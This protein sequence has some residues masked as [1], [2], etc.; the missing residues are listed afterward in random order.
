MTYL[1]VVINVDTRSGFAENESNATEM[2]NGCKSIDFLIDGVQNKINFFEGLDK[3][4]I[5]F[6]D[7]HEAIPEGVLNTLRGMVDTLVIRK[8]DKRFGDMK[9]YNKF[10]DLNYLSALQMARGEYIAHFDQDCAA[11]TRTPD[12]VNN[13]IKHLD[14]YS[15]VSYPSHWSPRAVNDPNYDY[16][17][18]STR[19]FICKREAL[20]FTEIQKCLLSDEYLYGE[21]PAS[22]RN[23]WFEHV[24][25]LHAKY[26]GKGVYYPPIELDNY[27]IFCWNKYITGVLGKL[28]KYHYDEVKN[29][30]NHCSGIVYPADITAKQI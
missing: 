22:R 24:I 15:F 21:Y 30:I 27:S 3:E 23:G 7:Q 6:I 28:N 26:N 1:S 18:V 20:D 13:L 17:W 12:S 8:H 14:T 25:G 29:Y 9:E 19:F 5:L 4:I 16:D 2:F 10:N 11:F